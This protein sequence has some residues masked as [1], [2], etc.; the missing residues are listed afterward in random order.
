[1]GNLSNESPQSSNSETNEAEEVPTEDSLQSA[2]TNQAPATLGDVIKLVVFASLALGVGAVVVFFVAWLLMHYIPQQFVGP[3]VLGLAFMAISPLTLMINCLWIEWVVRNGVRWTF[4]V[5]IGI[6]IVCAVGVILGFYL[7]WSIVNPVAVPWVSGLMQQRISD[8][9]D[10]LRDA[11]LTARQQGDLKLAERT[12]SLMPWEKDK[13]DALVREKFL[14]KHS[15]WIAVVLPLAA[16]LHTTVGS[17]LLWGALLGWNAA[18]R[19]AAYHRKAACVDDVRGHVAYFRSFK[20]DAAPAYQEG[21]WSGFQLQSEEEIL[22]GCIPRGV[23]FFAIGRPGEPLPELGATRM[24][25]SD[26]EWQAAASTMIQTAALILIQPHRTPSLIWEFQHIIN[27]VNPEKFA[28][29]LP[30][31]LQQ[32]DWEGFSNAVGQHAHQSLP[33]FKE[34]LGSNFV[35][36]DAGWNSH[37]YT[38]NNGSQEMKSFSFYQKPKEGKQLLAAEFRSLIARAKSS[39]RKNDSRKAL[40]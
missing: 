10:L 37:S 39:I 38:I 3:G 24:Y 30:S 31:G 17:V 21:F 36:F 25:F 35:V 16:G 9:E 40:P 14:E 19:S 34:I 29:W 11:V 27:S 8:D 7:F 15:F 33:E 23:R 32:K 1:M 6:R 2:P 26:D 22:A 5:R 20:S 18:K 12:G 13:L 28:I 4:P